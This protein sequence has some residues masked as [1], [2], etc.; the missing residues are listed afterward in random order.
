MGDNSEH[1]DKL[2]STDIAPER[3]RSG[4]GTYTNRFLIAL[5]REESLSRPGE[6][7]KDAPAHPDAP[8]KAPGHGHD[9][10]APAV[11]ILVSV[12]LGILLW[13]IIVLV[14]WPFIHAD[15]RLDARHTRSSASFPAD[16]HGDKTIG[17]V[18]GDAHG[19]ANTGNNTGRRNDCLSNPVMVG[20]VPAMSTRAELAKDAIP[21]SEH[22]MD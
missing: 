12:G 3:R 1:N 17:A 13:A 5:L 8:V 2:D 20:R 14:V 19:F 10:L 9:D 4:R 11:G 22:P 15:G 6:D 18:Y 21:V 16:I 7:T